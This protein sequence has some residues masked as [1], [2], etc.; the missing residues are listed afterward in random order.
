MNPLYRNDPPGSMP[1]SWYLASTTLPDL[2][3]ELR[4]FFTFQNLAGLPH[5]PGNMHP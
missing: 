2:R 1:D 4:G 5:N 3:P